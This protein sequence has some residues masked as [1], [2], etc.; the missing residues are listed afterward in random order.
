MVRQKTVRQKF[1]SSRESFNPDDCAPRSHCHHSGIVASRHDC[2]RFA[3]KYKYIVSAM[4]ISH[5]PQFTFFIFVFFLLLWLLLCIVIA[6]ILLMCHGMAW[7]V[8]D[9]YDANKNAWEEEKRGSEKSET[10]R[11]KESKR[12]FRICD[13]HKNT[14]TYTQYMPVIW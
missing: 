14:H 9:R 11:K 12:A 10:D 1:L 2:H 3:I 5:F 4:V 8:Q 13:V 7:H 6:M